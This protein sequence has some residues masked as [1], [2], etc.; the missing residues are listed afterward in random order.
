MSN[1]TPPFIIKEDNLNLEPD[2]RNGKLIRVKLDGIIL[3][4]CV[5]PTSYRLRNGARISVEISPFDDDDEWKELFTFIY[6]FKNSQYNFQKAQKAAL[7]KSWQEA[8]MEVKSAQMTL[9]KNLINGKS[10]I[11]N[12]EEKINYCTSCETRLGMYSRKFESYRTR[13]PENRWRQTNTSQN[14]IYVYTT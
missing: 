13:F 5:S 1:K 8:E 7:M 9:K 11:E 3:P 2:E 10:L 6:Y 12:L 14:P 4:R